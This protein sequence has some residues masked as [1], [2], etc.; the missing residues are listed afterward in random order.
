[1]PS[2]PLSQPPSHQAGSSAV[3]AIFYVRSG[4]FH[5]RLRYQWS[6][7][8]VVIRPAASIAEIICQGL[9][10]LVPT[11]F[12]MDVYLESLNFIGIMCIQISNDELAG[13]RPIAK[14]LSIILIVVFTFYQPFMTKTPRHSWDGVLDVHTNIANG[15]NALGICI[16]M[17]FYSGFM[18]WAFPWKEHLAQPGEPHTSI[19]RPFWDSINLWDLAAEIWSDLSHFARPPTNPGLGD[20]FGIGVYP[21][22]LPVTRQCI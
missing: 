18:M 11:A 17:I 7:K 4:L 6:V 1:M 22:R 10:Y 12:A 5:S 20:A 8:Y 15:L 9:M 13:R 2:G 14:F 19:W 16:E 3:G 21:C